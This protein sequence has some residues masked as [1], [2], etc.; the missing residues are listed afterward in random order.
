MKLTQ[1]ELQSIAMRV[2][3]ILARHHQ[4]HS[5]PTMIADAV[6][7]SYTT[8]SD[9]DFPTDDDKHRMWVHC[10][11]NRFR[12]LRKHRNHKPDQIPS[13]FGHD[14]TVFDNFMA[15][16]PVYCEIVFLTELEDLPKK[17]REVVQFIIDNKMGVTGGEHKHV[18]IKKTKDALQK[19]NVLKNNNEWRKI[20][21]VIRDW[22]SK[23]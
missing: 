15:T 12:D 11:V 16:T 8:V 13:Y 18:L 6:A 20:S 3:G 19:Q 10:A 1:K 14:E 21:G 22:V 4:F 17:A 2:A 23:L 7:D 9:R 5:D